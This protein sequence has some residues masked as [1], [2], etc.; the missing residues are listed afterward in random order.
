MKSTSNISLEAVLLTFWLFAAILTVLVIAEVK[1]MLTA[2]K[3]GPSAS[4]KG[5]KNV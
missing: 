5:D 1:I 2:I 4:Q 3:Q